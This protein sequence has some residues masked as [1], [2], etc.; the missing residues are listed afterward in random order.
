MKRLL[1]GI[2]LLGLLCVAAPLRAD[3]GKVDLKLVKYD[4]LTKILTDQKGK[5]VVI[6]FWSD[7]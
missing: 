7:T 2:A 1:S 6:D 3:D 4:E 5:V